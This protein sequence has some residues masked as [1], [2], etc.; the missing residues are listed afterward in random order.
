MT[1]LALAIVVLV[2]CWHSIALHMLSEKID[3]IKRDVDERTWP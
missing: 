2:L 1:G 3:T